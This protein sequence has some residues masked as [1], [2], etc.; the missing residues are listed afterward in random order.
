MVTYEKPVTVSQYPFDFY[1][2]MRPFSL[3]PVPTR[4]PYPATLLR[5]LQ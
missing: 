5:S 1:L 4:V 2:N 3:A